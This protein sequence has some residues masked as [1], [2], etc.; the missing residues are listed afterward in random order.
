MTESGN[1][2]VRLRG[3]RTRNPE[4][5][6]PSADADG[7]G[8]GTP[9]AVESFAALY[10]RHFDGV[11]RYC[12]RHLRNEQR[13]QDAAQQVFTNALE[14]FGRYHEDGRLQ[15]WLSRIARNVVL[16]DRGRD[17]PTDP[18]DLADELP[19]RGATPE[20]QALAAAGRRELLDAIA[21]LPE[22]QRRAIELRIRGMSGKE[23]ADA[24]G[25]S[26]EAARMLLFRATERLRDELRGSGAKGDVR[27]N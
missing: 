27:G 4:A 17:R 10:R 19:D 20:E 9:F 12:Y 1:V 11:Y 25:R 6:V 23:I 24:M 15:H 7:V 22:D 21:R 2:V 18:I 26:H 13:A 8:D 14:A 3:R 16:N 5:N